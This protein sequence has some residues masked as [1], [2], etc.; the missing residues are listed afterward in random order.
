MIGMTAQENE[1]NTLCGSVLGIW[2]F[3]ISFVYLFVPE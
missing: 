1:V 3:D 2:H